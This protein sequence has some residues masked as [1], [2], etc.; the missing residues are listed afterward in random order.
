MH[1]VGISTILCVIV[2]KSGKKCI[3]SMQTPGFRRP[4][5]NAKLEHMFLG[6]Y[7]HTLDEK[8]RLTIP[9]RFREELSGGAY[10]TQGFDHNLRLL[11]ESSFEAIS[12]KLSQMKTTD[13]TTRDLRRLIFAAAS[14][15]DF[16]QAGRILIPQ[17][18]REVASLESDAV[19]VGVGETI[20]IWSPGA[21]EAQV[22]RLRDVESNS[23]RFSELEL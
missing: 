9:A 21:W 7:R 8:G 14:Q 23:E 5:V 12:G 6:Q 22:M 18:L 4:A 10:L 13:P 1:F 2:G 20:E 16:D 3:E 19:I 15:V 17:F 11:T